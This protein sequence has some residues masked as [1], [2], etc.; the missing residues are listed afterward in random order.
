M[1]VSSLLRRQSI[2]L[3]GRRYIPDEKENMRMPVIRAAPD[4]H[5]RHRAPMLIIDRRNRGI[6]LT[7]FQIANRMLREDITA[8]KAVPAS[9]LFQLKSCSRCG[10]QVFAFSYQYLECPLF[11]RSFNRII[12]DARRQQIL[13]L[14]LMMEFC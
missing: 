2:F 14:R 13:V 6:A 5:V 9:A 12:S 11:A 10:P 3:S 1:R 4:R 8:P 7:P